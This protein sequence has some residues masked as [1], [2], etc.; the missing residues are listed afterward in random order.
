[1]KYD[2]HSS[3]GYLTNW[4]A[5][6]FF[7]ALER[8]MGTGAGPMPVF[9]ALQAGKAMT[10]KDLAISAAVEQPTMANTLA[11]M[12]RDG[13]VARR[14]DPKDGR[15]ALVELTT[16]GKERAQVA[17]ATALEVNGVAMTALTA[18]EQAQYY[19]LLHKVIAALERD[20]VAASESE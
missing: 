8:R 19:A 17:F 18:E 10:Q 16:L 14:P 7:R 6:L 1:M 3:A 15:S 20:A 12:E 2:R 9:F 11:R 4:A 5:R 13:L